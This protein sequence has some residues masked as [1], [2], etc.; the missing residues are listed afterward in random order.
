MF[1]REKNCN[2]ISWGSC[3]N[4]NDFSIFAI[5]ISPLDVET[6]NPLIELQSCFHLYRTRKRFRF[7]SKYKTRVGWQKKIRKQKLLKSS[8]F[9]PRLHPVQIFFYPPII[10]LLLFS[11]TILDSSH[12]YRGYYTFFVCVHL[13]VENLSACYEDDSDV[14]ECRR[15]KK[16]WALILRWQKSSFSRRFDAIEFE[17]SM[18]YR[19]AELTSNYKY[20][21]DRFRL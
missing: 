3:I 1:W 19:E 4:L 15:R 9:L 13:E 2:I 17:I 14:N 21:K 5:N 6:K 16:K 11:M 20:H 7:L 8:T 18:K 12:C 10:F